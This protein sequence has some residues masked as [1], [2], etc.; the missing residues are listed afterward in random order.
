MASTSE[1]PLWDDDRI[2]AKRRPRPPHDPWKPHGVLVEKERT[3]QG[4]VEDVATVFLVNR[5]CPFRCLMCDL[6]KFAVAQRV[7]SGAVASQ[8]AQAVAGLRDV[9]HIK[10]YNAGNFFDAQAIPPEDL[11]SIAEKVTDFASVLVECHPRL[12]RPAVVEFRARLRGEL[13]IAMGLETVHP[14]VLPRLNKR[15]T[16]DDYAQACRFLREHD[17]PVRAFILVRP[18]FLGE[19]E[20]L[21]WARRSLDWAF[22]QGVECCVL[23]PTRGGN[24]AMEELAQQGWFVPPTLETLEAALEYG[25]KLGRGRVFAD[26]WD[27]AGDPTSLARIEQRN[28]QG[29]AACANAST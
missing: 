5:E 15:M 8:V 9:R 1:L 27:V 10:L 29:W 21:E 20:S 23:I 19:Q 25:Q 6:W 7:P 24:G 18:P 12:I 22:E 2:V 14:E 16:L 11:P 4:L 3:R 17:I 28:L 26:L 13:Q